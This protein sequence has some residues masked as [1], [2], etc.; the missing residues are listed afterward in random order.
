MA[1][2]GH[3]AQSE[4]W[5]G[6]SWEP[7]WPSRQQAGL[8][9]PRNTHQHYWL[10]RKIIKFPKQVGLRGKGV[11]VRPHSA[12]QPQYLPSA[13]PRASG[14][15]SNHTEV[16]DSSPRPRGLAEGPKAGQCA[17]DICCPLQPLISALL[18]R[19]GTTCCSIVS[20]Q[21]VLC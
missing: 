6:F 5:T 1:G 16:S 13:A 12:L 2:K 21:V 11:S 20:H 19:S 17:S 3:L 18:Q 15:C 10:S 14:F 8:R 4:S 7:G 9:G